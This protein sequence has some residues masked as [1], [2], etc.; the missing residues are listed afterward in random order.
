MKPTES[1]LEILQVLWAKG[2]STVRQV[3]E[4]LSQTRDIGYTT[5][6]KLMQIMHEKGLLSRTEEGRYH[7]YQALIGEEETQQH[8]LDRFV[9]TAFRG[10]SMK[11]VMQALGNSK[12]TPQELEELQKLINHLNP[13]N[14]EPDERLNIDTLI[15]G[16]LVNS[17]KIYENSRTLQEVVIKAKAITKPAPSHSDYSSLSGLSMPDHLVPG[18]RFKGCNDLMICMQGMV[19]GVTYDNFNFYVTRDFNQGRKTPMSIFVRGMP[20]DINYL[21]SI[22][23][24]DIESVEVFL[25]DELGLVNR[26]YQTSGVLV[27][28]TKSIPQGTKISLAELEEL[29]P[30]ANVAK[31]SPRG[32][33]IPKAFYSPKYT[34]TGN[35][36]SFGPDLRTTVYWNPRL[37]TD[38]TTGK[39]S[40][41][42]FTPD[43][44]GT[45]RAVVE[46][47]DK[48]G[49]IGRAVYRF[50]VQ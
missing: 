29:L 47:I 11:L 24:S 49:H 34:V 45:Y 8:L 33:N 4:H 27:I 36:G 26:M 38:A 6:L 16:Y 13:E 2:P 30:Q 46:G 25:K 18:D 9:D 31:I 10:S 14:N 21:S 50:K 44:K 7:V 32:Y 19:T 5:T 43:G 42:F 1:E 28:N 23:A 3:N 40:A 35:G 12:A 48:D 17:K 22:K 39:T 15:S 41:E 20:V 37:Y